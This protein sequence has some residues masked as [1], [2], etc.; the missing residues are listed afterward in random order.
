MAFIQLDTDRLNLEELLEY[1]RMLV[2][3]GKNEGKYLVTNPIAQ[4]YLQT[5]ES[6]ANE[7]ES[8][9]HF[10][11]N[12]EKNRSLMEADRVRDR[13]LSVFR[14]LMQVYE[15]SEDN[16][17][18]AIAYEFLDTLWMKKYD[19]LPFLS[20]M[21][22]T[23][24][25]DDLLFDLSA[26]RYARHIRT[27]KLEEAVEKIRKSNEEFKV[28]CGDETEDQSI[29]PTYDA[30]ALRI[31]LTETVNLYLNYVR[32]MAET[33]DD[34]GIGHLYKSIAATTDRFREKLTARHSG[35]EVDAVNA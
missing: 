15:L 2:T 35:I 20:L 26:E 29:K 6:D 5:L 12:D 30:R 8:T 17:P 24:G 10:M 27:L 25:I 7:L 31:E 14:R 1:V 22:E 19:P 16:S 4:K 34:K 33:S 18:E 28:I 21:V 11:R 3:T 9:H 32:A 23:Q 13:A